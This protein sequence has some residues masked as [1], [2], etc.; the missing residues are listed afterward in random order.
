MN[1]H[2]LRLFY[3]T[4]RYQ[5]VTVAAE[6][7]RISQPAVTAQIK[8]LERELGVTL[9]IPLGRGIKLTDI[10]Q[11]IYGYAQDLFAVEMK[12]LKRVEDQ[13]REQNA[14][15]RLAGNYVSTR[16][17]LPEW[18]KA[19]QEQDPTSSFEIATLS[20]KEG[21]KELETGKVDLMLAG[22]FKSFS[23]K[24]ERFKVFVGEFVFL[25][26]TDHYL[27]KGSV[28][29]S[30]LSEIPFIG[31][32]AGSY[33]KSWLEELYSQEKLTMP[34]FKVRVN[35]PLEALDAVEG[36]QGVYVC[37]RKLAEEALKQGKVAELNIDEI[38]REQTIYMYWHTTNPLSIAS[39]RF[40]EYMWQ[41]AK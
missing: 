4:A 20:S 26:E 41:L 31:R 17:L 24:L 29:L 13:Q 8:K 5:S 6:T 27:T 7:L 9:L 16:Y 28:V 15:I 39:Q 12:I 19:Y 37:Q 32:D 3:E 11:E 36:G 33:T 21:L 25:I 23:A 22:D 18:Q 38:E 35:H 34:F 40:K 30:D 10:G 14:V 2:S 1:L